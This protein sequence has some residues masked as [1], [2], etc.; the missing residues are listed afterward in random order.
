MFNINIIKCIFKWD[1]KNQCLKSLT[2]RGPHCGGDVQRTEVWKTL[3]GSGVQTQ[4]VTQ[5]TSCVGSSQTAYSL[6]TSISKILPWI[7]SHTKR[8]SSPI[9]E[10]LPNMGTSFSQSPTFC[11]LSLGCI[12]PPGRLLYILQ[13]P[14]HMCQSL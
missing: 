12:F 6:P 4:P 1:L 7:F 2:G 9:H 14:V 5:V 10:M 11:H 8:C 3:A 13:N